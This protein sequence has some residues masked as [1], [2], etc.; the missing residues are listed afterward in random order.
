MVSLLEVEAVWILLPTRA[1]E[2]MR[3]RLSA[4]FMGAA[5]APS[6]EAA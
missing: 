3:A 2:E 6:R 5:L 4:V 1:P